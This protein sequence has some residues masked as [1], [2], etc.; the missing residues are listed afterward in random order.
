AAGLVVADAVGTRGLVGLGPDALGP[1]LA[2]QAARAGLPLLLFVP[3]AA[4]ATLDLRWS[5]AFG[6]RLTRVATDAATLRTRLS[7][8]AASSGRCEVRTD[9]IRIRASLVSAVVDAVV[10]HGP[11]V[12]DQVAVPSLLGPEGSWLAEL[13]NS[14]PVVAGRL[15]DET[16]T[17][18]WVADADEANAAGDGERLT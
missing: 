4:P 1:A 3:V 2:L 6:A 5:V 9:D 10:E 16:A 15:L 13:T 7:E 8:Q 11:A 18:S 14:P 12:V 17:E